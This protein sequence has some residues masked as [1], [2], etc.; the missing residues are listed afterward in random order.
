MY[1]KLYLAGYDCVVPHSA[2]TFVPTT[3]VGI[4]VNRRLGQEL[5]RTAIVL[6]LGCAGLWFYVLPAFQA[7]NPPRSALVASGAFVG[8]SIDTPFTSIPSTWFTLEVQPPSSVET[9]SLKITVQFDA[10]PDATVFEGSVLLQGAMA[11]A[12]TACGDGQSTPTSFNEFS[13]PEKELTYRLLRESLDEPAYLEDL[14]LAQRAS[15]IDFVRVAFS[16]TFPPRDANTEGVPQHVFSIECVVETSKL[17]NTAGDTT[18]DVEAPHIGVAVSNSED[19]EG[20]NG[21]L[22][23]TLEVTRGD[24]LFYL[25]GYPAP[26]SRDQKLDSFVATSNG[27]MWRSSIGSSMTEAINTRYSDTVA[28]SER[29]TNVFIAGVS[30]GLFATF[31]ATAILGLLDTLIRFRPLVDVH[32]SALPVPVETPQQVPPETKKQVPPETK[33][34]KLFDWR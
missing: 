7:A 4:T 19:W 12:Y 3:G 30:A 10:E 21:S 23:S 20:D 27:S 28:E 2:G 29:S 18:W 22:R 1:N 9:S 14:E 33:K 25:E 26:S 13:E 17:W 31:I 6:G 24:D 5:L 34:R 16:E 8:I 15:A 32:S 11:R